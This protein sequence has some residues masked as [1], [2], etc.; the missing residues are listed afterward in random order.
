V[1]SPFVIDNGDG[2]AGAMVCS[3]WFVG[4]RTCSGLPGA[5]AGLTRAAAVT[6]M[7]KAKKRANVADG[8]DG[9]PNKQAKT[10][11][12]FTRS[13]QELYKNVGKDKAQGVALIVATVAEADAANNQEIKAYAEAAQRRWVGHARVVVNC[14][15]ACYEGDHHKFIAANKTYSLSRFAG[16]KEADCPSKKE[17]K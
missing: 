16:C 1:T 17:Q 11:I 3:F 5:G 9:A 12:T 6:P 7:P 10:T 2:L 4:P 15:K 8:G 13:Y 14:V